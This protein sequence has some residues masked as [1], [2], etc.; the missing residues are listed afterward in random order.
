VIVRLKKPPPHG[1]TM[2]E[3]VIAMVVLGI[4]L[5]GLLP[6]LV[7]QWR[8]MR[9]LEIH[10]GAVNQSKAALSEHTSDTWTQPTLYVTPY[11]YLTAT[12]SDKSAPWT[13]WARKLGA[14]ALVTMDV[15]DADGSTIKTAGPIAMPDAPDPYSLLV[16]A[17]SAT[18]ASSEGGWIEEGGCFRHASVSTNV[19]HATSAQW[20]FQHVPNG[21]YYL[22]AA[23]T[24]SGTPTKVAYTATV[25]GAVAQAVADIDQTA[26]SPA[27]GMKIAGPWL[28]TD[29]VT[30]IVCLDAQ[31]NT[32]YDVIA[33]SMQLIPINTVKMTSKPSCTSDAATVSVTVT[34]N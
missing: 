5:S 21:Y 13:P 29:A 1:F 32:G 34:A 22:K 23:W 8:A 3:L 16:S 9:R 15:Y 14:S 6:L 4:A 18:Y 27:G 24:T 33:G 30:V 2:I 7:M 11:L 17:G 28:I 19:N 12:A 26:D 25:N 31:I 10:S 20:T